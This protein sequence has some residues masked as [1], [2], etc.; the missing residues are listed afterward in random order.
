MVPENPL[1]VMTLDQ[2]KI[3]Q[4]EQFMQLATMNTSVQNMQND[5]QAVQNE[6]NERQKVENSLAL[7]K[8]SIPP[9]PESEVKPVAKS[10]KK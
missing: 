4:Y 10:P 8:K 9:T 1:K 7:A 2:L 6:I 5:I 3:L